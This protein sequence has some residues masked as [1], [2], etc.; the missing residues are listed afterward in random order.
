M[1]SLV[2]VLLVLS[3]GLA[4]RFGRTGA[5]LLVVFSVLWILVNGSMEGPTLVTVTSRH[6]LTGADLAGVAGV[7]LAAYVWWRSER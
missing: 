5:L 4:H 6:G 1:A 7:A 2:L 3:A